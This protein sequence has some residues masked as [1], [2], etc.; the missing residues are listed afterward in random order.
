MLLGLVTAGIPA[1]ISY[2]SDSADWL[3]GLIAVVSYAW[4]FAHGLHLGWKERTVLALDEQDLDVRIWAA[5]RSQ[6]I[7]RGF[8]SVGNYFGYEMLARPIGEDTPSYDGHEFVVRNSKDTVA[9]ANVIRIHDE[10]YWPLA[11]YEFLELDGTQISLSSVFEQPEVRTRV[12]RTQT[13]KSDFICI[14]LTTHEV[15]TVGRRGPES[16]S[17][18]RA[19]S[20]GEAL[21]SFAG[22]DHRRSNFYAIGLGQALT[23]VEDGES[24]EARNQRSAVILAITRRQDIPEILEL[25]RVTEALVQNYRTDRINLSDYEFSSEIARRLSLSEIDFAGYV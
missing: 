2:V 3:T 9:V 13:A 11:I 12:A 21:I 15:E 17:V 1:M 7:S 25:D 20:L 23:F 16:L 10:A 24:T 8:D 18:H 5:S 22:L 19:Q 4:F 14:G 6:Q